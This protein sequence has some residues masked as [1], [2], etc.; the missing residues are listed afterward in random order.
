MKLIGD[1]TAVDKMI[2]S[3]SDAKKYPMTA[4]Q[5]Q[6]LELWSYMHDLQRSEKHSKKMILQLSV[7]D[8]KA[9]SI[10]TAGREFDNMLHF[11]GRQT[12]DSKKY[13]RE[14]YAEWLEEFSQL[15]AEK[16]DYKNAIYALKEAAEI[17]GLKDFDTTGPDWDKM[18]PQQVVINISPQ[19]KNMLVNLLGT[20]A[21]NLSELRRQID[22]KN[23][24][25]I[26]REDG[27]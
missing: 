21:I 27:E 19:I 2:K 16:H 1:E 22:F 14:M 15:S 8:K 12:V 10:S 3:L 17:R 18:M 20:G 6:Q 25:T 7:S 9:N 24:L 5:R 23:Q 4:K 26:S 11:Y 13:Y